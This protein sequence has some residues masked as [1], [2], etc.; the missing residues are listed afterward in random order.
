AFFSVIGPEGAA[1]ILYRDADRAPELAE[2]LRITASELLALG[3]I[4]GIIPEPAD[5]AGEDV[6][7]AARSI[8]HA[9]AEQLEPLRKRRTSRLL[10]ARRD[11]YRTIGTR[12]LS[13]RAPEPSD[14]GDAE[15]KITMSA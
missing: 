8:E 4:D 6:E 14:S 7:L 15:D 13:K 5:G 10:K 11:R 1:T 12:H 9:V 2:S 3:I